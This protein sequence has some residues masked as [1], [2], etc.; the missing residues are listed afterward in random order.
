MQQA[1]FWNTTFISNTADMRGAAIAVSTST[2]GNAFVGQLVVQDSVFRHNTATGAHSYCDGSSPHPRAFDRSLRCGGSE[3]YI[4][5]HPE[6]GEA[7]L[8]NCRVEPSPGAAA[9][10][11][12]AIAANSVVVLRGRDSGFNWTSESWGQGKVARLTDGDSTTTCG[13]LGPPTLRRGSACPAYSTEQP[14]YDTSGREEPQGMVCSACAPPAR[15]VPLIDGGP[16]A[17]FANPSDTGV[18]RFPALNWACECPAGHGFVKGADSSATIHRNLCSACEPGQHSKLNKTTH[19]ACDPCEPGRYQD[20]AGQAACKPCA[21]GHYNPSDGG[22]LADVD[23]QLC[24]AGKSSLAGAL[25]EADCKSCVAGTFAGNV[26]TGECQEC[27]TGMYT[28]QAGQTVCEACERGTKSIAATRSMS[29]TSCIA[30]WYQDQAA[31]SECEL[32]RRGRYSAQSN[33]SNCTR[34]EEGKYQDEDG[35]SFCTPL[36]TC[37]A[38]MFVNFS[39]SAEA[40]RTCTVCKPG[41]FA[42]RRNAA[43]CMRCADLDCGGGPLVGCGN[44]SAGHCGICPRGKYFDRAGARDQGGGR[45]CIL[46]PAGDWCL[47]GER[48]ECGSAAVFCPS[49]SDKPRAVGTHNCSVADATAVACTAVTD[50]DDNEEEGDEKEERREGEESGRGRR[51]RLQARANATR[52]VAQRACEPGHSC[53]GGVM[54]VCKQGY[55]CQGGQSRSC[56]KRGLYCPHVGMVAAMACPEG[57]RCSADAEEGLCNLNEVSDRGACEQCK[58]GHFVL[59][60]SC[61]ACPVSPEVTCLEAIPVVYENAYCRACSQGRAGVHFTHPS[62]AQLQRCRLEGVCRTKLDRA[63]WVVSTECAPGYTGAL[64]AG[65]GDTFGKAGGFCVACPSPAVLIAVATLFP[66]LLIAVFLFVTRQSLKPDFETATLTIVRIFVNYVQLSGMMLNF[67]LDWGSSLRWIFGIESAAGGGAPPL[68]DC[69]GVGFME[70]VAAIFLMP[71]LIP[72][73]AGAAVVVWVKGATVLRG[74][75]GEAEAGKAE[76]GKKA[77][78]VMV[79]GV[80][81]EHFFRNGALALSYFAWPTYVGAVFRTFDCNIRVREGDGRVSSFVASDANVSCDTDEYAA[82]RASAW[83]AMVVALALPLGTAWF[84]YKHKE[85][86]E[87]DNNFRARYLFLYGGFKREYFWWEAIVALR[88]VILVG[89]AVWLGDDTRGYQVWCGLGVVL[90]AFALQLWHSPYF[91]K[92]EDRLESLTLGVTAV[93]LLLGMAVLL[94]QHSRASDSLMSGLRALVGALNAGVVLVFVWQLVAEVRAVRRATKAR[95]PRASV[96]SHSAEAPAMPGAAETVPPPPRL[97]TASVNSA[98]VRGSGEQGK[99]GRT[100][101]PD[102][103]TVRVRTQSSFGV[104]NPMQAEKRNDKGELFAADKETMA[105]ARDLSKLQGSAGGRTSDV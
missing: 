89:V 43:A 94:G 58:D 81:P 70:Q 20:E 10:T 92:R 59:N 40:D 34:C 57:S 103:T 33:S 17:I 27:A 90:C 71:V 62:V 16:A 25:A 35:R 48:T 3:F 85:Q 8:D 6:K 60:N 56:T 31:Q 7:L 100:A 54:K 12:Y 72:C 5:T 78:A 44:A 22:T 79:M 65:C 83:L 14:L 51:R 30:G 42:D 37:G 96:T 24:A 105:W 66:L 39:G 95:D 101:A 76:A 38:G 29:C 47:G 28:N 102:W 87:D 77:E 13:A 104:V 91:N 67:N 52:M 1:Y 18:L 46:C 82:L 97:A 50:D 26:G 74:H 19:A 68:L 41:H 61:M 80:T 49:G 88:K 21:A 73:F 93:S 86:L 75:G 32:C 84:L 15:H 36:T 98:V 53:E 64:C 45:G 23:C 63:S 11:T 4:E 9:N 55:W 2:C 69:M 99:G